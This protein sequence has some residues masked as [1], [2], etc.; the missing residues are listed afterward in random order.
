MLEIC[1]FTDTLRQELEDMEVVLVFLEVAFDQFSKNWLFR[2]GLD[3]IMNNWSL[4]VLPS[5]GLEGDEGG[6][7]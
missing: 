5:H 2:S 3:T 1:H 7:D 4:Q 6:V